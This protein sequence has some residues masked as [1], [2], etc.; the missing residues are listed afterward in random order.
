MCWHED[1][2]A[3]LGIPSA[4]WGAHSGG[5]APS[6]PFHPKLTDPTGPWWG[7]TL[8][9][10]QETLGTHRHNTVGVNLGLWHPLCPP[11][12][13]ATPVWLPLHVPRERHPPLQGHPQTPF[14]GAHNLPDPHHAKDTFPTAPP[15]NHYFEGGPT[16]SI[17]FYYKRAV[18]FGER[19]PPTPYPEGY[20]LMTLTSSRGRSWELVSTM[21]RR[22]STPI[23][24]HTLPKMLCFP[25]SHCAGP[26][27]RKNWL[28]LVSGPAL[29]IARIPAPGGHG[30]MS[31]HGWGYRG[32]ATPQHDGR[33][34]IPWG[35]SSHGQDPNIT[36]N[37]SPQDWDPGGRHPTAA[38]LGTCHSMARL[39]GDLSP[40][41]GVLVDISNYLLPLV[42]S[43]TLAIT[44]IPVPAG[45][46]PRV[47]AP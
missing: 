15:K 11:G 32:H 1:P 46:G 26:S 44:R 37:M 40:D 9:G 43:P 45:H 24:W 33:H 27:V 8:G 31:S 39:L 25:S 38:I 4:V 47:L 29:A 10:S 41:G 18:Q 22:P 20:A 16:T 7:N 2:T 6:P 42:S 17:L 30:D 13:G 36:G 19:V 14:G 34:V 21:A 28:P 5:T 23:P 12:T 35:M 3:S